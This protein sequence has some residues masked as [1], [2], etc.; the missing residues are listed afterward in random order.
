[1]TELIS[2]LQ[3]HYRNIYHPVVSLLLSLLNSSRLPSNLP[4]N[5]QTNAVK[6]SWKDFF[7]QV[8]S[9]P[10]LVEV[11]PCVPQINLDLLLKSDVNYFDLLITIC[12]F[13]G[14]FG[15]KNICVTAMLDPHW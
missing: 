11:A 15:K 10:S 6:E 12:F 2:G 13:E 8:L 3:N 1:M 4:N 5:L 9:L 7:L 14:L